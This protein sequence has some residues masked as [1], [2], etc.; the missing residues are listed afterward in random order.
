M[1]DIPFYHGLPDE[2]MRRL[3]D[4]QVD[5]IDTRS[6]VVTVG[7]APLFCDSLLSAACRSQEFGLSVAPAGYH[8]GSYFVSTTMMPLGEVTL[9][10][11]V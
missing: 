3:E 4:Y 11:D 5:L 8:N 1:K 7:G 10:L 6:D 2:M 9:N